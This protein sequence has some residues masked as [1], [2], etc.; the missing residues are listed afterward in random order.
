MVT[1]TKAGRLAFN[2]AAT[3]VLEREGGKYA[4]LYWDPE[5]RS[6]AVQPILQ[7]EP[8]A[9]QIAFGAKGNGAGFSVKS[10][11]DYIVYESSVTRNFSTVWNASAARFEFS[12][13]AEAFLLRDADD[14][15][16]SA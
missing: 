15:K 13:P 1:I 16:R 3:E 4:N 6:V 2:R 10:F 11:L 9:Y 14:S 5:T 12:M 7:P 8:Q